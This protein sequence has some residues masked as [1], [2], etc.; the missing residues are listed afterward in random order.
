ML[1][2]QLQSIGTVTGAAL[3]AEI[4]NEYEDIKSPANYEIQSPQV[5]KKLNAKK[6]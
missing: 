2:I 3:Y 5:K 4:N 6:L 1:Y